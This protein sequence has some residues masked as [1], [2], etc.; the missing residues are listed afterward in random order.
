[1]LE[2]WGPSP[3]SLEEGMSASRLKGATAEWTCPVSFSTCLLGLLDAERLDFHHTPH[4]KAQ[5]CLDQV[6]AMGWSQ[7]WDPE[8]CQGG[9]SAQQEC[10][11]RLSLEMTNVTSTKQGPIS[12]KGFCVLFLIRALYRLSRCPKTSA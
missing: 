11:F 12:G 2:L 10:G 5:C 4:S 8:G 7:R 3:L 6:W 9:I 1:M